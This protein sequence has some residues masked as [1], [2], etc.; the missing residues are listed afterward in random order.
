MLRVHFVVFVD[1]VGT[2]GSQNSCVE[3]CMT[4]SILELQLFLTNKYG[5]CFVVFIFRVSFKLF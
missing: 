5:V 3:N 2:F 4:K 1:C